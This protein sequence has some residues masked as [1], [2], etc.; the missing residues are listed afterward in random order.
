MD[1]WTAVIKNICRRVNASE[2]EL[3]YSTTVFSTQC[4]SLEIYCCTISSISQQRMFYSLQIMQCVSKDTARAAS[5]A[6]CQHRHAD[7]CTRMLQ[8]LMKVLEEGGLVHK[9]L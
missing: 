1:W 3:L 7:S 6:S 5:V 4:K 9:P 2:F 8:V